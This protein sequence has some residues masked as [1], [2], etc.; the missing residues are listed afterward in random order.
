MRFNG[1][2][3]VRNYLAELIRGPTQDTLTHHI[4]K[5]NIPSI[6]DAGQPTKVAGMKLELFIFDALQFAE[7]VHA[8][9]VER[10]EEVRV[11]CNWRVLGSFLH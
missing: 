7:R 8:C 11:Q 2:A 1:D 3:R 5:K 4:A 6:D 10:D 9:Y